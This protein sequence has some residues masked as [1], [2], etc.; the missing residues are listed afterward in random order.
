[1]GVIKNRINQKFGKLLVIAE[2]G[3]IKG[4]GAYWMCLCDCGNHIVVNAHVLVREHR[5]SCGC[6][7][8]TPNKAKD[9]RLH[10]LKKLYRD[11]IWRHDER[12]DVGTDISLEDFERLI[13]SDC[14]YC[15]LEPC[16]VKYDKRF[17][18]KNGGR[19]S[20]TIIRHNE[21]DRIDSSRG[22]FI[23]NVVSCCHKCNLAKSTLSREQFLEHIIKIYNH[24]CLE[25]K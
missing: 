16:H 10:L 23:D 11:L 20:D 12:T 17:W 14:F 25:S 1:M 8:E 13:L 19:V 6:G 3:V 4:K 18:S 24:S 9:R 5:K 7:R 15:G 22:Y 21:I 2:A